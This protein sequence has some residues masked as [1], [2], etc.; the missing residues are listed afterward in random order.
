MYKII[1]IIC[2]SLVTIET[3]YSLNNESGI[4]LLKPINPAQAVIYPNAKVQVSKPPKVQHKHHQRGHKHK[5]SIITATTL[6]SSNLSNITF[7]FNYS[8]NV[9]G[10]VQAL[11]NYDPSLTIMPNLGNARNLTINL[12]LQAVKIQDIIDSI[13]AQTNNQVELIYSQSQDSIR[14]NFITQIDIGQ[15]AVDESLKWQSGRGLPRPVLKADGVVRFPY[16][17]YQPV[18]TCQPLNLCDIELEAGEEIQSI[19]IGDSLHWNEGDQ[20][21]P[22]V[23]SGNTDHLIP[24]LVLKPDQGGLA[25]TLMITTSKRTYMIK[26]KSSDVSYVARIGFYYPNELI[27]KFTLTKDKLAAASAPIATKNPSNSSEFPLVN[28]SNANFNYT[29]YGD[30]YPWRPTQVFDD[31]TS[32][33]IQLPITVN[34]RDLPGICILSADDKDKCE[35]VN[36]RYLSNYYIVDKLFDKARLVN[37]FNG[38][39]QIITI[40]HKPTTPSFFN[41]L[42]G[43]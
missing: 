37:G 4:L 25:T 41:R 10:V 7:D 36:F 23:Y 24:H 33:F 40:V 6:G 1:Y 22:V 13:N 17:E 26:L 35:L 5:R 11:Q 20:S 42:F 21:I 15:D 28:L 43:S 32:V 39:K 14:L 12:D 3:T 34:S 19:L 29:I 30:D 16:G 8:G 27:Q 2:L 38:T 31:G 18:V 9:L